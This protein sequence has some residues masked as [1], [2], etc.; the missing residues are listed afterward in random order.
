V[1]TRNLYIL[2]IVSVF[3]TISVSISWSLHFFLHTLTI[4]RFRHGY[5]VGYARAR[6]T[7]IGTTFSLAFLHLLCRFFFTLSTESERNADMHRSR[8]P[9]CGDFSRPASSTR[10][11]PC[12]APA[13]HQRNVATTR[14]CMDF[15]FIDRD[16]YSSRRSSNQE[17]VALFMKYMQLTSKEI[18]RR[19]ELVNRYYFPGT[20]PRMRG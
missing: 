3:W 1:S 7:N 18:D 13:V 11:S 14:K 17:I 8:T 19:K 10:T 4:F 9:P 2:T 16:F 6:A 12:M 20:Q 5:D 15:F